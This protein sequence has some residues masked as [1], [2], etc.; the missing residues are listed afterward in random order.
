[1]TMAS[2]HLP[3]SENINLMINNEKVHNSSFILQRETDERITFV[4][5]QI[6][7]HIQ[8]ISPCM[9]SS[10]IL[11]EIPPRVREVRASRACGGTSGVTKSMPPVL[12]IGEEGGAVPGPHADTE[13]A[14][15]LTPMF[16]WD[17]GTG[18]GKAEDE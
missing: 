18:V 1:M 17:T 11:L 5:S 3:Q 16:A 2:S 12:V 6:C 15:K 7:I 13:K 4:Y 8:K 10:N 14:E 9:S